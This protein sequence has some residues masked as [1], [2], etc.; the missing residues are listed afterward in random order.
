MQNIGLLGGTFDPIH[1]GHLQLA[2][3]ARTEV[4]LDK[5]LLLVAAGPPHKARDNVTPFHH[6]KRM[7]EL[8]LRDTD[9]VEPCFIE[10][11]LPVPSY[12][13]DT[14]RY[15]FNRDGDTVSYSFIVGID[16]FADFLSWKEYRQLLT[17]VQ[18]IVA[19]RKGFSRESALDAIMIQLGYRSDQAGTS[20][21]AQ[22]G[23]KDIYFLDS[24]PDDIS[25]SWIRSKLRAGAVEVNGLCP[26]VLQ[27]IQRNG[28]YL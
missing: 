23:L 17:L 5:V 7:L 12:T 9:Y 3:A 18:L 26:E 19:R 14:M 11:D 21:E 8:A 13:I 28:L 6:R 2:D 15:L 20:W 4:G 10:G 27:Y 16:A 22:S 1:D 24:Q 25:S